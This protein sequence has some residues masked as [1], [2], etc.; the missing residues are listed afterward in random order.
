[1]SFPFEM[2]DVI[3]PS[4]QILEVGAEPLVSRFDMKGT[5]LS[6]I[7]CAPQLSFSIS[8]HHSGVCSSSFF[9]IFASET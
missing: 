2:K 9:I 7:H 8:L 3:A 1:M 6:Q 5:V 4:L